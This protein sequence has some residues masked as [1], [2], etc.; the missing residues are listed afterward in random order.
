MKGKVQKWGNSL[1]IRI[2]RVLARE[3]A[4][5]ADTEVDITSRDGKILIS[6]VRKRTFTLRQLLSHVTDDNLHG[7]SARPDPGLDLGL[8]LGDPGAEGVDP[9]SRSGLPQ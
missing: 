4:M 2:P 7:A 8:A 3:G 6:P 5:D 1:G 9:V